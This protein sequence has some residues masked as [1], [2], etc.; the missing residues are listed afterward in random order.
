MFENEDLAVIEDIARTANNLKW[1]EYPYKYRRGIK[2]KFIDAKQLIDKQIN[3]PDMV[4][5]IDIVYDNENALDIQV[6]YDTD[7]VLNLSELL[8]KSRMKYELEMQKYSDNNQF[9]W[10]KF[11]RSMN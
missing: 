6:K 1:D 9:D 5:A 4:R 10:T 8:H 11:M 2:K 3:D 7:Q